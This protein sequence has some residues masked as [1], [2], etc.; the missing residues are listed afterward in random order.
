M[1]EPEPD[2]EGLRAP[3]RRTAARHLRQH[4]DED[5]DTVVAAPQGP[6]RRRGTDHIARLD[7]RSVYVSTDRQRRAATIA[8]N[9]HGAG[10]EHVLGQRA[11]CYV[12]GASEGARRA[13]PR[14]TRQGRLVLDDERCCQAMAGVE[15]GIRTSNCVNWLLWRVHRIIF[16]CKLHV[17][18]DICR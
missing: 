12:R 16:P 6:L 7:E 14:G 2:G 8:W 13:V 10:E 17:F 3:G 11:G 15:G 1:R 5:P 9:P 4:P 18:S